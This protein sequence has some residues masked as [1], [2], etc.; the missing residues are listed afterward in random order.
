MNHHSMWVLGGRTE[1]PYLCLLSVWEQETQSTS[2]ET[3]TQS[4]E[5]KGYELLHNGTEIHE[6]WK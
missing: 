6:V 2:K 3:K 1:F 4:T 5:Q